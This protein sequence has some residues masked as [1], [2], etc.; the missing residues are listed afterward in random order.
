MKSEENMTATREKEFATSSAWLE[1]SEQPRADR[2]GDAANREIAAVR[3][4]AAPRARVWKAW[5]EPEQVAQ[6]WG[7]NGFTNTI[8]EMEVRPGG[9]WQFVM[10]GPDGTDY[11]NRSIYLE[12]REP[13]RIVYVHVSG[14]QFQMTATFSEENGRT[15]LAVQM[16]FESA[17][18]RDKVATQFGAV[19]GLKQTLDRLEAF[20][21]NH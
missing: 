13:E 11:Q 15:A 16:L 9:I 19:E 12:V 2:I 7:P 10:H 1:Q 6:W 4:V 14:P 17:A 8:H 20:L 5:T 18:L 21:A 3:L